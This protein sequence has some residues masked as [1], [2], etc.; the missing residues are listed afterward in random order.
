MNS[1]SRW[2][3]LAVAV[4]LAALL[5]WMRFAAPSQP[6]GNLAG[7][8]L[9]GAFALINQ[10]GKP[11]TDR[12]F[13][14]RYRLMYFGYTFCPDICPTD[15]GLVA[16]GLKAFEA[17]APERA[18]RVQPIFVTVDPERD[19]PASLKAFVGAFHPRL[20]GLTGTPAAIDAAK[21]TFGIYSKKVE[22]SDPANYLVDHFAV[23]YLFGP[24]G[25]PIA[26]LPHGS[27]AAEVT[28]MLDAHVR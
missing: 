24:N 28:A 18:A 10:D 25:E 7:S 4:A 20:I 5:G 27:T 21:K 2:I 11:V 23:I 8:S 22:T 16:K 15:V 14:G 17:K 19:D 13:A 3:L 26:F 12:D 9:G 6:Q 1:R